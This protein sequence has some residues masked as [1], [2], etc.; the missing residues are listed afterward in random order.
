MDMRQQ[1]QSVLHEEIPLTR[2]IGITVRELAD[3]SI[4]LHAPIGN[5][6]NH[7]CT[8]FGGSLYSVA[9]LAGWGLIWSRLHHEGL[10]GHI[11]IQES[12]SRFLSPVT[13][14]IL[15][16]CAFDDA[17]ALDRFLG[18]YARRGRARITLQTRIGNLEAPNMT[19]EGTY[20]VHR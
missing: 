14:D 17:T 9:V 20:V 3:D 11:V 19:F 4:L 13:G 2:A 7:K 12:H 6:L 8:A 5:N 15:A 1:L 16:H 10:N 18:M